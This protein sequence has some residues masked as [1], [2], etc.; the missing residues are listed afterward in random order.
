MLYTVLPSCNLMFALSSVCMTCEH[1]S[2]YFK[3]VGVAFVPYKVCNIQITLN[4]TLVFN[5]FLPH[6]MNAMLNCSGWN[7]SKHID[8]L[9]AE[10]YIHKS[11]LQI[12]CILELPI[13]VTL[14]SN[15]IFRSFS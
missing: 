8:V 12:D 6:L 13:L 15:I 10:D 4:V 7:S 3:I 14:Y 2:T 5:I 9:L 1:F 11:V